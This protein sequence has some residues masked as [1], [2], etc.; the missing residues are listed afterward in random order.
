[1]RRFPIYD[2]RFTIGVLVSGFCIL[3]SA[4]GQT[5]LTADGLAAYVT[6]TPVGGGGGG[7]SDDL[8]GISLRYVADDV[9][10]SDGSS[11]STWP[12]SSGNSHNATQANGANQP[13]IKVNVVNGHRAVQFDGVNDVMQVTSLS[14][15]VIGSATAT[16]IF[17][18]IKQNSAKAQNTALSFESSDFVRVYATYMDV[19]YFDWDNQSGGRVNNSQPAGWDDA[20]H[21]LEVHRNGANQSI[22]VDGTS[23]VSSSSASGSLTQSGTGTFNIGGSTT[24][25]IY[26]QGQIAEAR[27]YNVN[28]DSTSS[29]TIRG[30]LKTT[31]GTP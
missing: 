24:I 26:L 31:Y 27:V 29:A 12:D 5:I 16:A 19:L 1:M 22:L 25:N 4:F 15:T 20:W 3:H 6:N 9:T 21:V 13:V 11:V 28:K 8:T 30:A 14:P 18:V 2:W 10:G 23:I 17:I 7:G